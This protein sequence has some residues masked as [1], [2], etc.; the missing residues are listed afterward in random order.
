MAAKGNRRLTPTRPARAMPRPAAFTSWR[1]YYR[2]SV[3]TSGESRWSYIGYGAFV[4]GSLG[5]R[6]TRLPPGTWRGSD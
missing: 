4:I 3:L 6:L 5:P 2:R 1:F